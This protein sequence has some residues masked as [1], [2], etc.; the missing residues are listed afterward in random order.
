MSLGGVVGG[1]EN[2]NPKGVLLVKDW[3]ILVTP[4]AVKTGLL[5]PCVAIWV[6]LFSIWI[7]LFS[8][9]LTRQFATMLTIDAAMDNTS[10]SMFSAFITSTIL[11]QYNNRWSS[12]YPRNYTQ[13]FH[14]ILIYFRSI[15]A[16]D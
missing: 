1:G 2:L 11:L 3:V 4:P 15:E 16:K 7:S 12:T 5:S 14:K 9:R 8:T 6:S 10:V 13:H